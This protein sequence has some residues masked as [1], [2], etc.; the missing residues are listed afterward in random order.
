M[1]PCPIIILS[2]LPSATVA[3]L[4][5]LLRSTEALQ[6]ALFAAAVPNNYTRHLAELLDDVIGDHVLM[7]GSQV[8]K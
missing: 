6:A 2:G 8:N 4:V 3:R 5:G 7:V 1:S